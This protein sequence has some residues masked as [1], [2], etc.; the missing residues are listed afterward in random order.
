MFLDQSKY[1]NKPLQPFEK[2]IIIGFISA[3]LVMM[4]FEI[5]QDF[6]T[7]KAGTFFFVLAWIPLL[8]IHEFGHAVM[9]KL[10]GWRVTQVSIGFGHKIMDTSF[11]GAPMEIRLIPLEGFV[12]TSPRS[13][14]LAPIKNA[15]IYFAGPGVELTIFFGMLA[16]F[17][18]DWMFNAGDTLT[19]VAL[20]A[21][22]FAALI[23]AVINLIPMG[24]TT[25][26]G[27]SAND[28]LGIIISLFSNKE[29][30]ADW[31]NEKP[32]PDTKKP[33]A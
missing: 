32:P 4:G 28:G 15:L 27:S 20:Q 3:F 30:Y 1:D 12:R 10:L 17:G 31:I 9:A 33:D 11:L 7:R 21:F 19:Q 18:S 22:A 6:E 23:G 13:T 29:D 2:V 16:Y 8:F 5:F 14:E 24:I 26:N 25:E